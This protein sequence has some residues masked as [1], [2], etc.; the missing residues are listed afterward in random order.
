[1]PRLLVAFVLPAILAAAGACTVAASKPARDYVAV[2]APV[3]ALTH[4]RVIDGTGKA[5]RGDQTIVIRAGRIVDVGSAASIRPPADAKVLDLSGRTVLP[6]YVML[7]EHLF[8]TPDGDGYVSAPTSFAPLYLAGGA[9]TVRTGG[10]I[11]WGPDVKVRD[12]VANGDI[13]GPE[14]DLTSPYFD[15]PLLRFLQFAPPAERGRSLVTK[16][17][18]RGATSFKAY[19]NLTREELS[20]V[21]EEAH[22][23]GLKVTGHLCATTFSDA[24]DLGIDSLEHGL[25]VATDF[26]PNREAGVC[27]PSDQVLGSILRAGWTSIHQLIQKLVARR[28][29]I[30]STLA[31]FETFVSTRSP[32]AEAALGL[33]DPESRERYERHRAALAEQP[34]P[35]WNTLLKR[36][37]D[38]EVAFVRAGGLLAAGSDPTGHG[39]LVAGFSNHRAIELLVEAGFTLPQ[40]IGIATLN[41]ARALGREDRIGSIEPGKQ[42]DLIVVR[43]DPE[44]RLSA[45][46]DVETVFKNGIGYD[47]RKLM[48]SVRGVAGER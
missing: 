8:Y 4:V 46:E 32:A 31:V 6:G 12:A 25:W 23:R 20:G 10:S 9:T 2:D 41:G 30:T 11:W 26:V 27:P 45:I 37:M 22:R 40:A 42:A 1:M 24:A 39:G 28:V 7:H 38:F 5:G 43:G 44:D 29:A 21:I 13:A 48:E 47:S 16:W 33:M 19:Q 18:E 35:V 15:G 34:V 14:I 17:A 36:E 3:L